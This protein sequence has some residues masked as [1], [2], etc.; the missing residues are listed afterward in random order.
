MCVL[1]LSPL[2]RKWKYSGDDD[3]GRGVG[4]GME[5]KGARILRQRKG[6]QADQERAIRKKAAV[7]ICWEDDERQAGCWDEGKRAEQVDI[8][9]KRPR[10]EITGM[11]GNECLSGWRKRLSEEICEKQRGLLSLKLEW[12][13]EDGEN[14][15]SYLW[16]L[17]IMAL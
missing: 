7:W 12:Q 10:Q 11:E 16:Y 1:E 17:S 13:G 8:N 14:V 3:D 6:E 5:K 9:R 2:Y 15:I 4:R